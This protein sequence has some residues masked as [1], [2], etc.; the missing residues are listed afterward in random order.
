MLD[1]WEEGWGNLV[2]LLERRLGY[3]IL[4][5]DTWEGGWDSGPSCWP[6][7]RGPGIVDLHVG[8]LGGHLG[9]RL[10]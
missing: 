5:L 10:G 1:T 2:G 6:L 8:H 3:W 4:V 9:G 7:G